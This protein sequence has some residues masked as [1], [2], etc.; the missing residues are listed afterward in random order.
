M[1]KQFWDEIPMKARYLFFYAA[2]CLTILP[3]LLVSCDQLKKMAPDSAIEEIAEEVI[4]HYTGIDLDLTPGTTDPD[5][6]NK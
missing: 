5:Q 4:E 6:T 3:F 2:G 1:L